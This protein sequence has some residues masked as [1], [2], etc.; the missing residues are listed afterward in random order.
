MIN[1]KRYSQQKLSRKVWGN[2]LVLDQLI[3]LSENFHYRCFE[4]LFLLNRDRK[5]LESEWTSIG[6]I[7]LVHL[8]DS[9]APNGHFGRISVAFVFEWIFFV[10]RFQVASFDFFPFIHLLF[11]EII[12][13][14]NHFFLFIFFFPFK[15]F[16]LFTLFIQ[17][18]WS[19]MKFDAWPH[20][21]QYW[22]IY[23]KKIWFNCINI[24]F[25][26]RSR[27]NIKYFIL[28]VASFRFSFSVTIS[29]LR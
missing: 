17:Y 26:V 6:E 4:K 25:V 3:L 23:W 21:I 12:E 9:F 22:K 19:I 1:A 13:E 11:W 2:W 27:R 14:R 8:V 20:S 10:Q 28:L 16:F 18:N 7:F 15:I 29:T 5:S 24:L